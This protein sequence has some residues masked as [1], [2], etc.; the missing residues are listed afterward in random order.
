MK[1]AIDISQVAY[2]GTGSGRYVVEL[3]KELV[4]KDVTLKLFGSAFKRSDALKKFVSEVSISSNLSSSQYPFPPRFFEILWNDFHQAPIEWFT[5]EFDIYHSSDWTQAPSKGL[6]VTTVHDLIPF[7]FPEYVHPRIVSAHTARWK[8]IEREVDAIIVDAQST[9]KDILNRFSINENSI[10]VV[11]LGVD[12][13]FLRSGSNISNRLESGHVLNK[14]D[15]KSKSYILS[16]GTLEPRKNINRLVEAYIKLPQ[17]LKSVY[18]LVI[19][20]KKSWAN[21]IDVPSNTK[22]IFTGFVE[23]NDLPFL[24]SE[25]KLFVMP[26]LYEGFGLPVLEAMA[27]R[28]PVLASA[29]SCLPEIGGDTISYFENSEDVDSI[30]RDLAKAVLSYPVDYVDLAYSKAKEMS[31]QRTAEETLKVYNLLYNSKQ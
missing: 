20:G 28:T 11:P 14:F 7:L 16:V 31:W 19:V 2:E 9:K 27:C 13:R 29:L 21:E 1:V 22:I 23:D 24:Y 3:V 8:W 15:L 25:A 26:S 17:D 18:P 30:S 10:Y 4:K 5:G 6:K 12:E